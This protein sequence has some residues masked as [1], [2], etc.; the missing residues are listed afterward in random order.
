MTPWTSRKLAK[1]RRTRNAA[2]AAYD[3]ACARRNTQDKRT[4]LAR[5]KAAT[6]ALMRAEMRA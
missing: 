1:L 5:L 3:A 2:Q 6:N 4:T